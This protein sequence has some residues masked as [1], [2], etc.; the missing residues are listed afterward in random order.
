MCDSMRINYERC[1]YCGACVGVCKSMA[2]ELI[3]NRVVIY[4]DRCKKC[5]ACMIVCPLKAL[6][7]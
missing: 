5:K 2:V 4:E 7:E 1:G 3:E 6:E